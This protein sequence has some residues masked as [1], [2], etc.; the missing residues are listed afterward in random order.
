LDLSPWVCAFVGA[1]P[2]R[3]DVLDRSVAAFAPSGFRRTAF[4]PCYG[5][6]EA[7]LLT[8]SGQ[9]SALPVVRHFRS[10]GL[11]EHRVVVEPTGG[12]GAVALVGC[13]DGLAA[14]QEIAIVRPESATVCPPDEVGEIWV[15]GPSV[16][17]GYFNRPEETRRDFQAHLAGG[18]RGPFLR[19]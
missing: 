15:A 1:E 19:T 8:S 10:A 16:A 18:G 11:S 17:Q 4:Y 13:G 12:E 14:D 5:L 6:A 3:P 7:T 2:V 9:L